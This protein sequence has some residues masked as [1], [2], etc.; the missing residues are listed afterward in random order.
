MTADSNRQAGERALENIQ[1]N[2]L[3]GKER[4]AGM[5]WRKL[6]EKLASEANRSMENGGPRRASL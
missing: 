5:F 2:V 1:S 6:P 4:F 3:H